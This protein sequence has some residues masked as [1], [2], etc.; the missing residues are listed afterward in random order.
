[1]LNMSFGLTEGRD[2]DN[3]LTEMAAQKSEKDKTS[4]IVYRHHKQ[5]SIAITRAI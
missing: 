2:I 3:K 5:K 1:M 4:V